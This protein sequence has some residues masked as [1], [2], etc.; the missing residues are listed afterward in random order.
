LFTDPEWRTYASFLLVSTI[1]IMAIGI[2]ISPDFD[3][4]GELSWMEEGKTAFRLSAFQAVSLMSTT[5]YVTADYDRWNNSSRAILMFLALIGGC[6]G[7]TSGGL[8]VIRILLLTKIMGREIE[9]SYHPSVVRHVRLAGEAIND[10][11]LIRNILGYICLALVTL[12]LF[13]LLLVCLE[14]DSTWIEAGHPASNKLIDLASSVVVLMHNVGPGLG[15]VGA[16]G[17]YAE[18]TAASKLLLTVLMMLGRIEIFA[19][20]VL[21]IPSFW[22]TR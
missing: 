16:T 1:L 2:G 12:I 8:K 17:N 3:P 5:G 22:R 9:H 10:P 13:W 20:L 6:A 15:V 4:Q 18:F 14:P 21:V 11:D 19:I 7:S